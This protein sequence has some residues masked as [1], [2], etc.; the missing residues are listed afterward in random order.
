MPTFEVIGE[1]H[2]PLVLNHSPGLSIY[3]KSKHNCSVEEALREAE[4]CTPNIIS[5]CLEEKTGIKTV[6]SREQC[7][8]SSR[9][10]CMVTDEEVEN[11]VCEY[12]YQVR[13]ESTLGK[14]VEIDFNKECKEVM[15]TV[16]QPASHKYGPYHGFPPARY[17]SH[18]SEHYCTEVS[19]E[20]CAHVPTVRVT[21]PSLEVQFPEPIQTC[22]N[23]PII[24]PRITCQ[25]ITEEKCIQVPEI[26]E[27]DDNVQKCES[28]IIPEC[29]AADLMLPLQTCKE[30]DFGD[31][32]QPYKA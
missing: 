23:K 25:D 10:V 1:G 19:Q 6:T 28:E 13:I 20:T 5:S 15:V 14:T 11:E 31:A 16:C 32:D 27:E 4:A 8:S 3:E 24:L 7:F 30:I 22:T 9:T 18:V 2:H 21:Q 29:T 17:G 26:L 12:S